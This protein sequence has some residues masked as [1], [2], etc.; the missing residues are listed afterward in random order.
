MK[1]RNHTFSNE[2]QE[3]LLAN[4]YT[5]RVTQTGITFTLAFKQYVMSE[6]QKPGM[7]FPRILRSA[8][9]DPDIFGKARCDGMLKRI[10]TEA[11]SEEGLHE[12]GPSMGNISEKDLAKQ[13]TKTAIRDLQEH[14]SYLE[15]EVEFLKKI[16]VLRRRP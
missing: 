6:L 15:Q 2:E 4:P 1:K 16:S 11:A 10:R 5:R 3:S 7:T 9:Y 14:V 13:Q 12:V 8:G